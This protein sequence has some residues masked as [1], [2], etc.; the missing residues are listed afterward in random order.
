MAT[1]KNILTYNLKD[2][3]LV[4]KFIGLDLPVHIR[5]HFSGDHILAACED[6]RLLWFDYDSSNS[7][8]KTFYYHKRSLTY[9][10]THS[11]YPL[12]ATSARDKTVHVFHSKVY[13]DYLQPPLVLPLKI[14]HLN[15]TPG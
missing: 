2:Q 12:M 5:T 4:K 9:V 7:P 1:S 3:V 14:I 10:D 6:K 13:S 11:K 8:Y 15:D